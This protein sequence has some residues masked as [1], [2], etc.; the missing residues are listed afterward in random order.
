MMSNT[1]A[2]GPWRLAVEGR[3]LSTMSDSDPGFQQMI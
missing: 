3:V 1:L 2:S